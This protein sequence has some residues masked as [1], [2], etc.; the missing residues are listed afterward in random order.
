MGA[1]TEQS[2]AGLPLKGGAQLLATGADPA[3]GVPPRRT[4]QA[5]GAH[6]TTPT[7]LAGVA[8][9]LAILCSSM[10]SP[11]PTLY[12]SRGGG[13]A[14]LSNVQRRRASSCVRGGS[15]QAGS[16][17]VYARGEEN[18]Q[19]DLPELAVAQRVASGK[20]EQQREHHGR[21]GGNHGVDVQVVNTHN[22]G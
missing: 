13:A 8:G 4:R 21:D 9:A 5:W 22:C 19:A 12:C 6:S 10:K 11:V 1:G 15:K 14:R 3:L 18:I 16:T 2:R 7:L 17:P 20:D